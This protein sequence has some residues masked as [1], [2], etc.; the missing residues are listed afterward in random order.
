MRGHIGYKVRRVFEIEQRV[1]QL[2][3]DALTYD[4]PTPEPRLTQ[5]TLDAL[6]YDV[7]APEPKITQFTIDVLTY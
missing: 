7:P 1:T 2:T 4:T 5:L 3:Y 6:T